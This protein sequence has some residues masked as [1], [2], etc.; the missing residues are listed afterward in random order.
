MRWLSYFVVFPLLLFSAEMKEEGYTINFENVAI[1]E[2]IRFVSKI[3][4]L[5]FVY[6]DAELQF[7]VTIISEEATELTNI[8]A[9]LVQVLRINGFALIDDGHNLVITKTSTPPGLAPIVSDEKP[10]Q[11]PPPAIITRIFKLNNIS[12]QEASHI[13]RPLLSPDVVF[14]V[15]DTSR[16]LIIT[17]L[18]ANVA[19]VA[20]LLT[21]LDV[22]QMPLDLGAYTLKHLTTKDVVPLANEIL[23]PLSEGNPIILVPQEPTSTIFIVSTPFLIEKAQL[24]LE[25]LD[26]MPIEGGLGQ[27]MKFLIYKVQ[28][29]DEEA[30]QSALHN[31]ATTLENAHY[32]DPALIQAIDS[33]RYI[34]ETHSIIFTGTEE[35][36]KKL[37]E[38][39]PTFDVTPAVMKSATP[40][41]FFLYTPK[42]RSGELI[43]KSIEEIAKNLT[44][45]GLS[46]EALLRT[47]QTAR[48]LPNIDTLVFTGNTASIAELETMLAKIDEPERALK[49][50]VLIYPIA[51]VD[52]EALEKSMNSLKDNLSQDDPLALAID[53]MKYAPDSNSLIF[54]G[55]K[56]VLQRIKELL[57]TFDTKTQAAT[58]EG[59]TKTYEIVVLKNVPGDLI[60]K[61]LEQIAN[62]MQSNGGENEHQLIDTIHHIQWIQSTNSLYI[63]GTPDMI[64]RIKTLIA[65][66]DVARGDYSHFLT[67]KPRYVNGQTILQ[68][69]QAIGSDLGKSGLT[70]ASVLYAI[71]TA[72]YVPSTDTLLFTGSETALKKIEELLGTIDVQTGG[73]ATYLVYKIKFVPGEQLLAHL[74]QVAKDLEAQGNPDL[75]LIYT[76]KTA[77]YIAETHSLVFT[78]PKAAVE[79]VQ[80]LAAQFDVQSA[81][82]TVTST[83]AIYKVKF[84][85]GEQLIAHLSHVAHDLEIQNNP[86]HALVQTIKT[87]R[88]LP[89]TQSIVFTGPPA[90]VE[91][92]KVMAAEFD[93]K[94]LTTQSHEVTN[95]GDTFLLY[96]PKY[97]EGS[98]LIQLMHEFEIHLQESGVNDADLFATIQGLQWMPKT[99][100]IVIS[101]KPDTLKQ[102]ME[103]LQRF[104]TASAAGV[105]KE[106]ASIEQSGETNFLIYK[107]Q[108]HSGTEIEDA[109]R[110]IALDL[111]QVKSPHKNEDL[112]QAIQSVQWIETTNSIVASGMPSVLAKLRDLIKGIDVPLAQVFIEILVIEADITNDLEIGLRWGSQGKYRNKL[113]WGGGSQQ[114]YP[115]GTNDPFTTYNQELQNITTTKTPS[116]TSIPV[117]TQGFSLGVIGDIIF[118]KGNAYASLGSLIDAVRIDSDISIVLNQKL[119]TQDNKPASLFVGDNIPFTGSVIESNI[120]NGQITTGN[121]EYRDVGISLNIT[122]RVGQDDMVT[123]VV[124]QEISEQTNAG[125]TGSDTLS[126]Q[127][128]G[129]QT[130]K[131]STQTQV[132][133]PSNYFLALS[134]AMRNTKTRSR[135]SIPCLGGL[136]VIGALFNHNSV[137][138][139]NENVIIFIKPQIIKS[140]D[141][142]KNITERLEELHRGSSVAEDFDAALETVITPDDVTN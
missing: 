124:D 1:T 11:G 106:Q 98:Q 91:Q 6:S 112:V 36:L 104:D 100:T 97:V 89:E 117:D 134:G 38:L 74:N 86:D 115:S 109:L 65:Q 42:Y 132:T 102:T 113:A 105:N 120:S 41:E 137:L 125:T 31:L 27:N 83:F 51:H 22:P 110:K 139:V 67:Y 29:L 14:Q 34:A 21:V 61:D 130:S 118:L 70:D 25:E 63:P 24:I 140:F 123:L 127:I 44:E 4:G 12:P 121:I 58:A 84:V 68:H 13:I 46:D 66:F 57:T 131:R 10:L 80:T 23:F 55:P 77:R 101:G 111:S 37:Q 28:R 17:D 135:Q 50:D 40:S 129:I 126:I 19:R 76:I 33:M 108:Y 142:Y 122:P 35:A 45:S 15:S 107:L 62:N 94:S 73:P 96:Q 138:T 72:K 3:G 93:R 39:L 53:S 79:Q 119:I 71:N 90:A 141:M 47:L 103:L 128:S 16:H 60:L 49:S 69:L 85:P 92:A 56:P 78:G 2:F 5:N 30:F 54:K 99:A 75:D 136:P 26:G 32:N 59:I 8:M 48:W 64:D 20:E 88:Y 95:T 18:T 82:T 87:A 81:G 52:N 43:L 116:G 7:N 133:M 9:V 114:V